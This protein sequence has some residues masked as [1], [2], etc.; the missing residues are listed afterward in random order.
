MPNGRQDDRPEHRA[1][2]PGASPAETVTRSEVLRELR[3]DDLVGVDI[4]EYVTGS[5]ERVDR[6]RSD[7]EDD[8][9][10]NWKRLVRVERRRGRSEPFSARRLFDHNWWAAP[11]RPCTHRMGSPTGARTEVIRHVA[12]CVTVLQ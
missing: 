9:R 1:A 12:W 6:R 11:G 8:H 10:D 2:P 7:E 5:N 4:L 3:E